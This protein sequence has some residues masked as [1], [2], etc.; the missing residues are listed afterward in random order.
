M[1]QIGDIKLEIKKVCYFRTNK[2]YSLGS[3]FATWIDKHNKPWTVIVD[4]YCHL[5]NSDADYQTATHQGAR[6][7]AT[8]LG[9]QVQDGEDIS[10]TPVYLGFEA[11]A[12]GLGLEICRLLRAAAQAEQRVAYAE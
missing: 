3:A 9:V 2:G 1:T 12:N 6:M 8:A 11:Q 10:Q 4:C 7:I 5:E